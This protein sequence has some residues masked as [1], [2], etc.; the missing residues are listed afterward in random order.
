MATT[1]TDSTAPALPAEQRRARFI[2]L[3]DELLRHY[4]ATAMSRFVDL[5]S[6]RMRVHLLDA[7]AGEPVVYLHGGDGEAVNWAPLV[8]EL[9]GDVRLIGVDRPGFGLSDRIDY[10]SIDLRSHAGT[11]VASLLD[12]LGIERATIVG[13]SMG[14]FFALCAALDHPD[15]VERLVLA[16]MAV[17]LARDASPEL[18]QLCGA[19]GAAQAFM[20]RA[21]S[22]EAQH[23]QYRFMFKIDPATVP[24][25]YF[26]TRL[27]GLTLPGSQDTWALLLTRLADLDGF[28]PE[29]YL[30][31]DLPGLRAPVLIL[32][33]DHDMAPVRVAEETAARIPDCT[34]VRLAG[35][36]HFPFLEAPGAT[37]AAIRAFMARRG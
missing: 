4:G 31:D 27:A 22:L 25:L 26:R 24:D 32:W 36:G 21:A 12:A 8:A 28:K 2:E 37:A 6:P 10:S 17:G 30:G 34:L 19:P 14:G 29:V 3:Q 13:G 35:V 15:R 7:G 18:R 9:Q 33:G 11:F 1:L 5:A 20:Q 23:D 16:G